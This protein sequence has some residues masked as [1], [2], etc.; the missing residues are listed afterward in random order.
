MGIVWRSRHSGVGSG[1]AL[2]VRYKFILVGKHPIAAIDIAPG[3]RG[4]GLAA[5]PFAHLPLVCSRRV[6][7]GFG[8]RVDGVLYPGWSGRLVC[9]D[10]LRL[11]A[12][13]QSDQFNGGSYSEVLLFCSTVM[14]TFPRACPSS[15]Y[16][17]ASAV[18]RNG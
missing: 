9:L 2:V 3:E 14:T 16:R 17:I 7:P 6:I 15:R 5:E 10:Q 12:D 1:M 13:H 4:W 11:Y 18:S 8:E